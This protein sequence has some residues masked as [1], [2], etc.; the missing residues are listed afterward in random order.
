[1]RFRKFLAMLFPLLIV[2]VQSSGWAKKQ[3]AQ[4]RRIAVAQWTRFEAQFTSA[5]DYENPVQ[6][7]RVDV[8]FRGPKG[9]KQKVLAFWDGGRSWKVRFQPRETGRWNFQSRSVPQD[10]G[11]HDQKGEF[12]CVPYQGANPLYQRGSIQLSSNRRYLVHADGTPFF[13]LGD[14][15][16]NGALLSEHG[17]WEKYLKDRVTKGF[18][19]I[20]FVT[21]QWRAAHGDVGGQAAYAGKERISINPSFYQRMDERVDALNEHA[22]IAA[23]VLIWSCCPGREGEEL[24]PGLFLPEDQIQVLAEYMVARWGAHQVIW[25]L[26]GDGDYRG[27]KAERWKRIGRAIFDAGV[28]L[29]HPV[30]MHPGGRHWVADEFRNEPWFT[31]NG[32]QSGHGDDEKTFEWLIKGPPS[33]NWRKET[34]H[35]DINLEPNYEGHRGYTRRIIFD[36]HAI[37]RAAYWSLLIS[38]AAGVSYG[39]HG[40]WGWH[41]KPEVPLN[42][43]NTGIA[44][45]W[46]EAM[47]LPGSTSMRHLKDLFASLKWWT[48]RPAQHLL[49]E[50]PGQENATRFIAIAAAEDS[51]WALAYIPEGGT[52][53]LLTETLK[54]PLRARWF[55]PRTGIWSGAPV[56]LTTLTATVK[57]PDAGDWVLWLGGE[58]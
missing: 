46:H 37:R 41:S 38:P 48:L 50:Q 11:L 28:E 10:P 42:H 24:S 36:D 32:Y 35:P 5:R 20:K 19:A 49:A 51:S 53:Q 7:V 52:I 9:N 18:T 4:T 54:K 17:D 8:E 15:A 47:R 6:D 33:E 44:L 31:F 26:G 1:M 14:T 3:S 55:N 43:P 56:E 58:Q 16:W 40:M 22:L 39:A 29:D 13:W 25:L 30:T 27:E 23:P 45:P 12:R 21:T 57:A 34:H 2:L